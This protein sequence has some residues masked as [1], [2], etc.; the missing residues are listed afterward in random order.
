MEGLLHAVNSVTGQAVCIA[1]ALMLFDI[2]S[3]LAKACHAGNASSTV[4]R[5]GGWHKAGFVGMIFLAA[6]MQWSLLIVPV[7]EEV[8]IPEVPLVVTACAYIA[9]TEVVSIFEN[10]CELNPAIAASPLGRLVAQLDK[11]E[12]V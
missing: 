9:V 3:G 6:A 5:E 10:L 12:E 1:F 2:V 11:K 4:M 7:P 8:A